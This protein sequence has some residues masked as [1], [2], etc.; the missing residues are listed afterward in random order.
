[1]WSSPRHHVF[2]ATHT[3]RAL[4]DPMGNVAKQIED[5]LGASYPHLK[6]IVLEV[7]TPTVP[8]EW[9]REV[10]PPMKWYEVT[11]TSDD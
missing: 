10:W 4:A 1:M 2:V 8:D 6:N 9:D 3:G 5:H 11:F 7:W